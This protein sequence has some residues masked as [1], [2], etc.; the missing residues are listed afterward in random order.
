MNSLILT[1]SLAGAMKVKC[2]KVGMKYFWKIV[3]QK[4]ILLYKLENIRR[5]MKISMRQFLTW[6]FVCGLTY[7]KIEVSGY[8]FTLRNSEKFDLTHGPKI[9]FFRKREFIWP[10]ESLWFFYF[11]FIFLSTLLSSTL[12]T[13][14]WTGLGFRS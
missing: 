6:L 7:C 13:E 4:I 5:F 10:I 9:P 11:C 8:L 14:T 1:S 3:L 12:S 2:E